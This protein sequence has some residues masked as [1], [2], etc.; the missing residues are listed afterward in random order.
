MIDWHW[1]WMMLLAPLPLLVR[2]FAPAART[3]QAALHVPFFAEWQ[4]LAREQRRT[5]E[6]AAS[7]RFLAW[8]RQFSTRLAW[9]ALVLLAGSSGLLYYRNTKEQKEFANNVAKISTVAAV[10][11]PPMSTLPS[12]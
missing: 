9:A 8:W 3:A 11:G 1:P 5:A 7:P 2:R 12:T 6:A 10:P 4:Q